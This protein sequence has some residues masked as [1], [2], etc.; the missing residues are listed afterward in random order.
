MRH[1]R[2]EGLL[3]A[4][5]SETIAMHGRMIHGQRKNGKLYEESQSYD[6]QGRVYFLQLSYFN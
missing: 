1:A 3:D 4:V 6:A 5:L 2:C